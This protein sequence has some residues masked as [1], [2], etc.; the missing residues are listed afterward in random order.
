[1]TT[2]TSPSRWISSDGTSAPPRSRPRPQGYRQLE[3]W[4]RQFGRIYASGIEGTGSWGAGLV[5][6]L[7]EHCHRLVEVNRPDRGARHRQGKN[8]PLD[9]EAAARAALA[10]T[11]GWP[12]SV[13]LGAAGSR[14]RSSS[15]CP[16]SSS[17]S[18]ARSTSSPSSASVCAEPTWATIR[19]RPLDGLSDLHGRRSRGRPYSPNPRHEPTVERH[20]VPQVQ[21]PRTQVSELRDRGSRRGDQTQ[22]QCR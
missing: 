15:P 19:R 9:A 4:A 10:G 2:S 5:R 12:I 13:V 17:S 3:S 1:M 7:R 22:V 16:G 18:R 14:P 21:H 6:Q 20:L 11:P 8:D